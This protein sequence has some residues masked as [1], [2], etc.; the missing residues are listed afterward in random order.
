MGY[1]TDFKITVKGKQQD[2]EEFTE[3]LDKKTG[4]YVDYYDG[5]F[6]IQEAKWYDWEKDMIEVSKEHPE[7]LFQVDGEG[8][9]S[10][11]I[12]RCFF[13]RGIK[14]RV[15]VET[16]YSESNLEAEFDAAEV[17]HEILAEEESG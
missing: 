11:D 8:E 14:E 6:H 13:H 12:W 16:V 17:I 9:E 3:Y 2:E 4:Y 15:Q 1:Y 10:G 7:N 5:I